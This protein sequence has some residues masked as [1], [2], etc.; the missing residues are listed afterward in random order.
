[1]ER[2]GAEAEGLLIEASS[3]AARRSCNRARPLRRGRRRPPTGPGRRWC[4]QWR[5]SSGQ[6]N[7]STRLSDV[8]PARSRA[9]HLVRDRGRAKDVAQLGAREVRRC[10]CRSRPSSERD[11]FSRTRRGDELQVGVFGVLDVL[12]ITSAGSAVQEAGPNQLDQARWRF[13]GCGE[14]RRSGCAPSGSPSRSGSRGSPARPQLSSGATESTSMS[15]RRMISASG[16]TTPGTRPRTRRAGGGVRASQALMGVDG[17]H[18][19][20]G[21]SEGF[22][23]SAAVGAQTA[24]DPRC[25][26]RCGHVISLFAQAAGVL[27]A[28]D[29]KSLEREGPAGPAGRG[30]AIAAIAAHREKGG[31]RP[32][33]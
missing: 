9:A 28:A 1:M 25:A 22:D 23:A 18:Q 12:E 27:R 24:P 7:R 33:R 11:R 10:R 16:G 17:G 20:R 6:F 26:C 8:G 31:D 29:G 5:R 15:Y 13:G 30:P 4:S 3:S 19:S 32:L 2:N 21:Q 14:G